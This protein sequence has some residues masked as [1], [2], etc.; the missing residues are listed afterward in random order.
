MSSYG[1]SF[2][3]KYASE[4]GM[5]WKKAFTKLCQELP[6]ERLR[7]MTYWDLA[8]PSQGRY[9]LKV[10][11]WQL[12]TAARYGKKVSLCLG[13]RQPRWPECHEPAWAKK[14]DQA[15]RHQALYEFIEKVVEQFNNDPTI[16][17]WQLENEALNKGLGHC[18]DYDRNRLRR[19]F[20]LVKR[21]DPKRPIIMS[22][23]D[24][25]GLPLRQP[26]PDIVG[27]SIY[28]TQWRNGR[29][30]R[31]KTPAAWY[32]LRS[33][34][35]STLIR[36]PV[37]IH[38]LQ[39]EPWGPEATYKLPLSEQARSMDATKLQQMLKYAQTTGIDHID[40]WGVEWWYWLGAKH[41]DWSCWEAVS[42]L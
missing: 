23:S 33:W 32:R 11:T 30:Y 38:E 6:F 2:S 39:T 14:L 18:T 31:S 22:T 24:S 13:M 10:I 41:E 28:K 3:A 7:L 26:R 17:S 16:E 35:V 5:D 20:E 1:V 21:L 36:R 19:E 25:V 40:L 8:E 15:A 12:K 42:N 37:I 9:D 34:L 4:M 29:Y 27:F